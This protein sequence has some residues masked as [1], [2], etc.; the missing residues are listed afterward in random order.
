MIHGHEG[1]SLDASPYLQLSSFQ[2]T[3][4]IFVGIGG[5]VFG[6]PHLH[7]FLSPIF[8]LLLFSPKILA[9]DEPTK[10]GIWQKVREWTA[11]Q[12]HPTKNATFYDSLFILFA[13]L[14]LFSL[15]WNI[16]LQM[17]TSFTILFD[18]IYHL[19]VTIQQVRRGRNS[20]HWH[21][22]EAF[23]L[24]G[25]AIPLILLSQHFLCVASV[26]WKGMDGMMT[27]K[28]TETVTN[29]TKNYCAT[30]ICTVYD[31]NTI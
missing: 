29:W 7:Q 28:C 6:I 22:A 26:G 27:H 4:E 25:L 15:S 23:Q 11:R 21:L 31:Y 17:P 9:G 30:E 1:S 24:L 20:H 2:G 13:F 18:T 14:Y 3:A 5:S 19:Q 10:F 16:F 8:L 12:N